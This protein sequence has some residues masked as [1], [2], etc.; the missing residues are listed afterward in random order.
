MRYFCMLLFTALCVQS[1]V[2]AQ[3]RIVKGKIIDALSGEGL[4]GANIFLKENPAFGTI[5]DF[6]GNFE[7]TVSSNTKILVFSYT[8]YQTLEQDITGRDFISVSLSAGQ[9]LDDVII[10]GYGTVRRED[11]TGVVQSVSAESFNRGAIT[12]PQELL[13]GK[14]AGVAITS[15]GSP[16]GGAKIRIRGES[17]LNASNDPL[18]VVDG[19]PLDNAGLA[20]NRN[21][22]NIINPNDIES[23]T[24]LKDASAAAIYGNRASGGVI[25]ITTKKSK[26][27]QPFRLSYNGNVSVQ[28]RTRSV[29]V[30]GAEEFRSFVSSD[31]FQFSD[32]ATPLMGDAN[33]NWQDAIFRDAFATDHSLSGAG[34]I[35]VV[36][37]RVSLGYTNKDGILKTDNFNRTTAAVNLSPGL[38]DNRLQINLGA[39]AM[40]SNNHF[41]DRG[42]IGAALS[43]DPTQPIFEEGNNFGGYRTWTLPNGNPNTLAPA[44]PLALLDLRDDNSTV[45]QYILNASAD[46]RFEKIPELRANLNLGM[47]ISNGEGTIIVPPFASFAFDEIYGGGVDNWYRQEKQNSLLEFYLNY[48]KRFDKHN[49]D[50]MAGYSWQRFFESNSF[51][52]SNTAGTPLPSITVERENL[53]RELFLLSLFTRLNYSFDN[54]YL[55]T[56]SVRRDGTS[57]FSPEN[58]WGYFPAAALAVKLIEN[59]QRNFNSVKL[60]AGVGL[61]GQQDIG[62]NFYPYLGQYLIGFPNAAYQF[63]NDTILTLRPNGYNRNLKWEETV[64]YNVGADISIVK[65]KF[66]ASI[67]AYQRQ[68]KDLLNFVPLPALS[69]LSNEGDV[70]IGEMV[71]KGVEL[72]LNYT[73]INNKKVNWNVSAN[74]AYNISEITKLTISDDPDYI[75]I[76]RGGIAGGVGSNIQVHSVGF[77]PSSFFVYEQLYDEAGKLL[78]GNFRDQN[79]DGI[80]NDR[81]LV[82]FQSPD[83]F[84]TMGLTS[85]LSIGNFDFSF[86]GRANIGNY[87]YNNIQTD[88]GYI[89]RLYATTN[90]L[91]NVHRS[92]LDLNVKDQANLT[93]SDHFVTNGSFFRMDH[94]TMGYNFN[95]LL[96]RFFRLYATVQNPFVITNY[97]G[98]DPEI[99]NG[100]DNNIYPRPR[101]ILFGLSVDF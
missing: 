20:G 16:G 72:A 74:F 14:I 52:N 80:I 78:E 22:L 66:S 28:S 54:K 35:G 68:T 95:N 71:S 19:I 30:L 41:A 7:L 2:I 37:F 26:L 82:R 73:V 67:D 64:T 8:G 36:P 13:A 100:I 94:I 6:D 17:S 61:T 99:G 53:D 10:I 51:R 60:R 89:N 88:M 9:L 18:I 48:T 45:N 85:N 27:G 79:G 25:I 24:V 81:D 83:P 75:G 91:N 23:F 57:R 50:L 90:Y 44:N 69:N 65:E 93:F 4:I 32:R 43:F 38:L 46:Y 3:E 39:K 86:A 42:A 21:P 11:A 62:G 84:W 56:L 70:N 40:I 5:T 87:I 31:Q 12:G 33:T 92:A 58:R 47:D 98:L 101:T 96:G 97:D 55:L 1:T 77:R 76:R 34:S 63:G 49:I 29:P 15:D 59:D